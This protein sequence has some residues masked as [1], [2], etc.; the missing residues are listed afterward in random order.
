MKK[1]NK[2]ISIVGPTAVGKTDFAIQLAHQL[3]QKNECIGVDL[4]SV[5]S[6]QVYAGIEIL[7]GADIPEDFQKVIPYTNDTSFPYFISQDKKVAL[8]GV[9]IIQ[10]TDDW[11]VAHFKN[12]AI[13]IINNAWE[14]NRVPILVGGT[15]LYHQQLFETDEHLHVPP[16]DK[17]REEAKKLS[18]FELQEWLQKVTSEKF[19]QM[20]N[21][22][23]NNPR[24]IV[25]ALEISLGEPTIEEKYVLE[26]PYQLQTFGLSA[27][28]DQLELRIK[29]R[30][31]KRFAVGA[32]EQAQKIITVCN[33]TQLPVCSTLGFLDIQA[34]LKAEISKD[35]C[36]DNWALH[37]Y[38]Y[39]KRQLTWWKNKTEVIWLDDLQKK[40]YT[41]E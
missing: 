7:T 18:L 1:N 17:L 4:I 28:L 19:E 10:P 13:P 29:K 40:Q 26:Q 31:Q 22:D 8:H 14:A 27:E 6:R 24:R 16:N 11:S 32:I 5:D 38:Q 9:S 23:R 34:Y 41:V 35:E 15:G 37:E 39:A 2:I 12:F 25:R 21:S 36:I 20:N 33:N 3:I 30:V